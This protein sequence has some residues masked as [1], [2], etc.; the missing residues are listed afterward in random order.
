MN[1]SYQVCNEQRHG[2]VR[3]VAYNSMS[4]VGHELVSTK[5]SPSRV[6]TQHEICKMLFTNKIFKVP[7]FAV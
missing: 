3:F 7:Q 4:I 2:A 6:M 5:A 1:K